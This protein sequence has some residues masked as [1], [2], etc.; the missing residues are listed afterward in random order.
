[1]F[2]PYEA[3]QIAGRIKGNIKGFSNYKPPVVF[4]TQHFNKIATDLE[5]KSR[6]LASLAFEKHQHGEPT[7]IDKSEYKTCDKSYEYILVEQLFDSFAA[8]K[9]YLET[10]SREMNTKVKD[11]KKS[12]I[13][14]LEPSGHYVTSKIL[15]AGCSVLDLNID[16]IITYEKAKTI[17]KSTK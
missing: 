3:S 15:R 8:A 4:T 11:S 1:M 6:A 9:K 2:R 16:D 10:K 17:S 12:V 7:I 14:K 13:H 5:E